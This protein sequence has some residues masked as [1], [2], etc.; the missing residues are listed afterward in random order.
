LNYLIFEK[1]LGLD[2]QAQDDQE[3]CKY[4]SKISEAVAAVSQGEARLAFLLNPTRIEQVQ[5]VATAGLIMPRKSTYFYPKVM[6]GLILS[7]I[8]PQEEITIPA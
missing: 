3:T 6:T 2:A 1:L 7:P 4:T 5:E 8:N